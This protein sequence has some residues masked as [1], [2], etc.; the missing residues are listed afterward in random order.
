MPDPKNSKAIPLRSVYVYVNLKGRDPDGIVDAK[1]YEKVQQEVIDALYGY[2]D[3]ETGKRPVAMALSKQ[4]AQILGLYG[5]G[6]GD[7][8]YATYPWFGMQHG[9]ILPTAEW[10]I[11]SLKALLTMTGP[12]IKK[13]HRLQRTVWLTDLVPTICYLMDWPVPEQAEG[14]VIYQAFEDPNFKLKEVSALKDKLARMETELA[15]DE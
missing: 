12:G 8:V 1:D 2:V 11:G 5:D 7:V 3:P 9:A 14:A 4:D 6:V 13:G 15:R 10:G